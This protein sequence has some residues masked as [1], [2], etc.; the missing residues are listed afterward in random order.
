MTGTVPLGPDMDPYDN[1]ERI[2]IGTILIAR[3]VE[4]STHSRVM[5]LPSLCREFESRIVARGV[6]LKE[7]SVAAKA[8]NEL[9]SCYDN[10]TIAYLLDRVPDATR[11]DADVAADSPASS[12][13]VVSH[14]PTGGPFQLVDAIV[15]RIRTDLADGLDWSG[16]VAILKVEL[17]SVI[18]NGSLTV[19]QAVECTDYYRIAAVSLPSQVANALG[20]VSQHYRRIISSSPVGPRVRNNV[21]ASVGPGVDPRPRVFS[22]NSIV[23]LPVRSHSPTRL[24]ACLAANLG[25]GPNSIGRSVIPPPRIVS[26]IDSIISSGEASDSFIV[27]CLLHHGEESKLNQQSRFEL[28]ALVDHYMRTGNPAPDACTCCSH[29]NSPSRVTSHNSAAAAAVKPSR[30]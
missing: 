30:K 23:R 28:N 25:H 17:Q 10:P 29:L 19:A 26:V 18:D 3:S 2:I 14:I 15:T 5:F 4:R 20:M 6:T 16:I 1:F 21:A 11:V 27:A 8:L 24:N 9:R 22:G 13:F 12:P 7:L